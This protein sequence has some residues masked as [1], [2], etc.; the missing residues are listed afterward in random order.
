MR[1]TQTSQR[2]EVTQERIAHRIVSWQK[3]CGRHDLP[4]QKNITAYR[5]WVS[6]IMLQQT[7]VSTVIPYFERFMKRFPQVNDLADCSEDEL[8]TYWAGLGYYRRAKNMHKASQI[9]MAEHDGSLPKTSEELISLPGIGKST[10]HA[11][12]SITY[13][14]PH[15]ILDGNV[16]RVLARYH[17]I[18]ELVSESSTMNRLW[19]I[20]ESEME[21][22]ECRTYTQGIMDLGASLCLR[23]PICDEC[24]IQ[25]GC[26]AHHLGLTQSIPQKK[27]KTIKPTKSFYCLC[28]IHE[29]R[30][31][32]EQRSSDGI[33]PT[34]W[35]PPM[36]ND[37][38]SVKDAHRELKPFKHTLTHF[39]MMITPVIIRGNRPIK[40]DMRWF[41]L[42]SALSAGVPAAIRKILTSDKLIENTTIE[43][44]ETES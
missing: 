5:V 25:D 20:A 10:A 33:W 14:L 27:K 40:K 1:K 28:Y 30:I 12:L 2:H 16:K 39:H 4:W 18:R 31:I 26:K 8:M 9:I 34:L 19:S 41:D 15:A 36:A 13:N 42:Q 3:K 24:P 37:L 21:Q 11:I 43:M 6:E 29:G 35:C 32:M 23:N 22:V 7:Q 17:G 38:G 44:A